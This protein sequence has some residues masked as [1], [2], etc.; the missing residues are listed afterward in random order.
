MSK[1][2]YLKGVLGGS[3]VAAISGIPV[4]NENYD[5]VIELLKERFGKKEVITESLYFK[6]QSLPKVSNKLSDVQRNYE[7]TEKI[8]RQLEAQGEEIGNQR[9]LIQQLLGKYSTQVRGI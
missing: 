3:A 7:I 2:S 5:L 9:M 6:L 1:F 8:L 4:T